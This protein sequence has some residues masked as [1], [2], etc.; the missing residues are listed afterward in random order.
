MPLLPQAIADRVLLDGL[1]RQATADDGST[2]VLF[3]EA[4]VVRSMA[5]PDW[6]PPLPTDPTPA[7]SAAAVTALDAAAQQT[8]ADASALRQRILTVAQSSVG[9]SIDTLT[10]GQVRALVAC[11]LYKAS[12]IDKAGTV[13]PLGKWL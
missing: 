1:P 11:L 4:G 12:A 7:E 5:A 9:Q 13:Q 3:L 8:A 10:A 6:P 2:H